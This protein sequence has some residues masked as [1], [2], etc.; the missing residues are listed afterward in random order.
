MALSKSSLIA[1][2]STPDD[3]IRSHQ[4]VTTPTPFQKGEG[5]PTLSLA[6]GLRKETTMPY[7]HSL[8]GKTPERGINKP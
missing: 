8:T 3:P 1:G 7:P 2:R 4:D 5:P 6:G